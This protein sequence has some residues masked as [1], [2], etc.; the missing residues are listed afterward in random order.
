[1]A[2][3]DL[4][5]YWLQ[6][7]GLIAGFGVVGALAARPRFRA[8]PGPRCICC[9]YDLIATPLGAPCP[10]CGAW[11]RTQ[12]FACAARLR[13]ETPIKAACAG[14]PLLA[15]A[16]LGACL[17]SGPAVD[18]LWGA[19]FGA[20]AAAPIAVAVIA[21]WS[22]VWAWEAVAIT[23]PAMAGGLL[24]LTMATSLEGKAALC[25]AWFYTLGPIGLG[26][27]LG[28]LAVWMRWEFMPPPT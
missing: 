23:L 13:W 28:G 9:D 21:L 22:R 7:T 10:E 8:T 25:C 4:W 6:L 15:A 19:G 16:V 27:G 1:M 20:F 18:R 3:S 2:W 24:I 5:F 17:V 14:F 12:V 11:E 26:A